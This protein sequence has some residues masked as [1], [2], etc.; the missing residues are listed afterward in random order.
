MNHRNLESL[1]ET[2]TRSA[3]RGVPRGRV[4]PTHLVNPARASCPKRAQLAK[5]KAPPLGPSRESRPR[6]TSVIGLT[7]FIVTAPRTACAGAN[8]AA[9]A[10]CVPRERAVVSHRN[11]A[12]EGYQLTAS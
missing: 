12:P 7:F 4:G 3:A 1:I 11:P 2:F 5:T 9:A 10:G 8:P 6:H